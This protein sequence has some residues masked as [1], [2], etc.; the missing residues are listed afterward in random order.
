MA[1][2]RHSIRFRT[3]ECGFDV[4]RKPWWVHATGTIFALIVI[5]FSYATLMEQGLGH[6]TAG[7]LFGFAFLLLLYGH[8]FDRFYIHVG[9]RIK[10]GGRVFDPDDPNE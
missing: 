8:H 3:W 7:F 1:A 4:V 5:L 10:I 6:A 9:D 2:S